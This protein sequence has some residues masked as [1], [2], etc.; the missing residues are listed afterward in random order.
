MGYKDILQERVDEEDIQQMKIKHEMREVKYLDGSTLMFQ[1]G[2]INQ[3]KKCNYKV[4]WLR[5]PQNHGRRVY[6][7]MD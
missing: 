7:V 4:Q 6:F 2:H 1:K 3:V 5:E